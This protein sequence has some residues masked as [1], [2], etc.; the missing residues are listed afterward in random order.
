MNQLMLQES[1]REETLTNLWYGYLVP[2]F[3]APNEAFS[4]LTMF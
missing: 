2:Q 3:T 1:K 4:R